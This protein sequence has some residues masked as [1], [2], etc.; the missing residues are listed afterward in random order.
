VVLGDAEEQVA[1][2]F[3]NLERVSVLPATGTGVADVIG[4]SA[5]LLSQAAADALTDRAKGGA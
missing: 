4:A 1:L 2:S 5:L 3:R